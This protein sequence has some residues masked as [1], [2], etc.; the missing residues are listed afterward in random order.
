MGEAIFE[1]ERVLRSKDRFHSRNAEGPKIAILNFAHFFDRCIVANGVEICVLLDNSGQGQLTSQESKVLRDCSSKA[2]RDFTVG[3][4]V[5][6]S[7]VWLASKRLSNFLRVSLAGGAAV[8][9]ARWSLAKSLDSCAEHILAFD[10]SRM[11]QELAKI[12]VR[13][14]GNDPQ[15]K[16]LISKHFYSEK[17]FDDSTADHP[18]YIYR[19]RNTYVDNA[20]QI[21]RLYGGYT[22]SDGNRSDPKYAAG[23]D[24][25]DSVGQK[26]VNLESKQVQVNP[27]SYIFA[28]P[29]DCIL[30]YSGTAEEIR[31]PDNSTAPAKMHGRSQKRLHRRHR[32]HHRHREELS[33]S[34]KG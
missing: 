2:I 5:A 6:A 7:V 27:S 30:G 1:L 13:R 12:I 11:Q 19:Q 34:D 10:G 15:K 21:Q 31:H 17:V 18:R 4:S 16:Q 28:D 3:G 20:A 23:T 29:L 9:S 25:P 32:M 14:Y 33:T 26:I 8:I 22:Q 24:V